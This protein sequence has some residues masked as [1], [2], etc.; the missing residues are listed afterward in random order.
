MQDSRRPFRPVRPIPPPPPR[1]RQSPPARRGLSRGFKWVAAGLCLIVAAACAGLGTLAMRAGRQQ[2]PPESTPAIHRGDVLSVGPR[3]TIAAT[4]FFAFGELT[5]LVLA[6]DDM[7]G[8]SM[9]KEGRAVRLAAGTRV[10]VL[11][12]HHR[13]MG[14]SE[15]EAK[16]AG[17]TFLEVRVLDGPYAGKGLFLYGEALAR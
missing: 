4:D 7:G 2:T 1:A 14:V 12:I 10:R 15:D 8:I 6:Q 16:Q 5:K 3:D 13:P 9:V 17:M 11:T